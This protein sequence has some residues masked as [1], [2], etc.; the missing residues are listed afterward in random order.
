VRGRQLQLGKEGLDEVCVGMA[1]AFM[2]QLPGIPNLDREC[3]LDDCRQGLVVCSDGEGLACAVGST[4]GE[5]GEAAVAYD[6]HRGVVLQE[7]PARAL[8]VKLDADS[9]LRGSCHC[10]G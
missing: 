7:L 1:E 3:V 4:G 5:P 10:V 6:G 2:R 8:T 9:L